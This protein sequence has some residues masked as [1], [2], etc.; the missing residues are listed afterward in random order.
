[1]KGLISRIDAAVSVKL[2]T[3]RQR[4][5]FPVNHLVRKVT[6]GQVSEID[7]LKKINTE[8]RVEHFFSCSMK[9]LC[10]MTLNCSKTKTKI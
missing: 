2:L 4:G 1:M 5:V 8:R 6:Y 9:S 7:V 3:H 10:D